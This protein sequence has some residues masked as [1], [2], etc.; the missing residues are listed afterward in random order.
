MNILVVDD[1][2]DFAETLADIL[3]IKGHETDFAFSGEEAVSLF[4]K[5]EFDLAFIDVKLPG[6]NG[7]EFFLD[8]NKKASG[9]GFVLMTGYSVQKLLNFAIENGAVGILQ[10]PFDAEEALEIIKRVKSVKKNDPDAGRLI[11]NSDNK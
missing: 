3:K 8:I 7:V 9:C 4:E 2:C 5:K 6:Q 10:K 11:Y 1:N